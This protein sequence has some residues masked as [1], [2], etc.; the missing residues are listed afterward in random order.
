[1]LAVWDVKSGKELAAYPFASHHGHKIEFNA[2]GTRVA[3]VAPHGAV[4]VY[5]AD[6]NDPPLDFTLEGM[7]PKCAA[8]SPNGSLL[9]VGYEDGTALIWDV[10][11]K[12]KE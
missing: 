5:R 4:R 3:L 7:R 1:V 11:A 8:F 2:T 12:P 9:A 6:A 10:T